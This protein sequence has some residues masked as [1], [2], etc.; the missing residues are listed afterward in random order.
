[1][2]TGVWIAQGGRAGASAVKS[3]GGARRSSVTGSLQGVS[4]LLDPVIRRVESFGG[5]TEGQDGPAIIG[6]EDL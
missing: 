6:V 2:L 1:M 3:C 5:A 4:V